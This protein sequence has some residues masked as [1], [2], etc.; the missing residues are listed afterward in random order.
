M[1]NDK[2]ELFARVRA[3]RLA[4]HDAEPEIRKWLREIRAN[5]V[6]DWRLLEQPSAQYPK[7]RWEVLVDYKT[8]PHCWHEAPERVL[9]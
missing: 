8:G 3:R 7:G 1:I 2:E 4:K 5:D 6:L 9:P